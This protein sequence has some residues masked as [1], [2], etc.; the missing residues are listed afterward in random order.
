MY[1]F[2][3][4]IYRILDYYRN[5]FELIDSIPIGFTGT[6]NER[7]P[8]VFS[9]DVSSDALYFAFAVNYTTTGTLVRIKSTSPQYEWMANNDPTPQDTP[10]ESIF[11]MATQALPNLPLVQPFF[12]KKDGKI[13]FNFTN[14]AAGAVTGGII[15][16]RALKLVDPHDGFGWDYSI[17]LPP[18]V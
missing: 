14:A 4:Y 6:A 11:G 18:Q 15:T 3:K 7:I 9:N 8:P 16:L 10:V 5:H 2:T 1:F 13:Q 17:G 12:V